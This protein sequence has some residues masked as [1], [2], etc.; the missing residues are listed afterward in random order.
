M[1]V[2]GPAAKL[3][4]IAA[5]LNEHG[6]M[7]ADITRSVSTAAV[8]MIYHRTA[9]LHQD[10]DGAMMQE[11]STKPAYIYDQPGSNSASKGARKLRREFGAVKLRKGKKSR[12][13]VTALQR[14]FGAGRIASTSANFFP[15]GYAQFKA[16]IG[17]DGVDLMVTGQ[18]LGGMGMP[19]PFG[20][21]N[22]TEK[23][24]TIGFTDQTQLRKAEGNNATRE[25]WGIGRTQ[26]ERDRLTRIS[27]RALAQKIN[28][29]IH[30]KGMTPDEVRDEVMGEDGVTVRD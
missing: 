12:A 28:K 2:R 18:M 23:T 14:E 9:V 10:A 11:Y 30:G 17:H 6:K 8:G 27:A 26:D 25:F 16:S 29:H 21:T 5:A 7:D 24:A 15:G 1:E 19:S 22:A 3:R 4:E 20:V 13:K